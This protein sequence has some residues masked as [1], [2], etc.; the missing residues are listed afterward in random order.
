MEFNVG[1]SALH[2]Q[3]YDKTII[4]VLFTS[5]TFNANDTGTQERADT[6][7]QNISIEETPPHFAE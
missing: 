2:C 4:F 1:A 6:I 5:F 7:H 3:S